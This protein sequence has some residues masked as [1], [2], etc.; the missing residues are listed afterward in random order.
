MTDRIVDVL[1]VGAGTTGLALALQAH[2]HGARVRII[3]RRQDL[4]RPSR[5]LLMHPRTLEVLRPLGVTDALLARGDTAAEV[6]LHLRSRVV[7]VASRQLDLP[8]TAFP[9]LLV[10]R[11]ADVEAVLAQALEERGVRIERGAELVGFRLENRLALIRRESGIE[12]AAYRYLVGCDG[13]ASLVRG[14]VGAWRGGDYAQEVVLADLG[15]QSRSDGDGA[16]ADTLDPGSAHVVAARRGLLF[17]FANGE[18]APWRML[19][20]RPAGPA[21]LPFGQP[22]PA[23]PRAELQA[24]VDEAG[25]PATITDV[26]WSAQV[27]LQHRL[28]THFRRGPFF[29]AGDVAHLHSPAG[30]QGMNTGIQDA[31]NLG[32]KLAFAAGQVRPSPV[33]LNSYER[34]RRPA[35]QLVLRATHAV[36]VPAE[37][38]GQPA[39]GRCGSAGEK[40]AAS[41]FRA[42]PAPRVAGRRHRG[43]LRGG[44]GAAA[45]PPRAPRSA[46]PAA[47]RCGRS[48]PGAAGRGGRRMPAST[49]TA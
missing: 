37:L 27:R 36:P 8:G 4:F 3:E 34:E 39:L 7:A 6:R 5:A 40:P 38:P 35:D 25:L 26:A 45:R 20:T 47:G 28:A 29:L 18:R 14:R 17:L 32:W 19:A 16:A 15:L 24:L 33:L 30:G 42:G 22:G 2:D 44:A 46:H 13:A 12:A 9:H 11:Q 21:P 48:G 23:V 43:H 31:L 49:C 41:A 1:V 10:I